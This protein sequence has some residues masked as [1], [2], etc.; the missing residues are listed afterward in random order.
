MNIHAATS[1]PS[2]YYYQCLNCRD[3]FICPD[4]LSINNEN[5]AS[6]VAICPYCKSR[7]LDAL[8]VALPLV[9]MR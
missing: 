8:N 4:W 1:S 2:H 3:S 9:V 5:M 7:Q 6:R